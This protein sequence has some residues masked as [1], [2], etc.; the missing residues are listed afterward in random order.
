MSA[1]YVYP[2]LE[3]T[4]IHIPKT[5]GTTIRKY[6]SHVTQEEEQYHAHIPDKY[7]SFW[8]FTVVRNPFDRFISAWRYCVERGWVDNVSPLEFLNL[9]RSLNKDGRFALSSRNHMDFREDSGYMTLHHAAPMSHPDRLV[10][11]V[12]YLGRF[13]QLDD[14]IQDLKDWYEIDVEGIHEN[15]SQHEPFQ[16]YYDSMLY[17]KVLDY[18]SDD[19]DEFNYP[20]SLPLT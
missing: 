8:K 10:E 11:N 2:E 15:Q 19:F 17:H 14:V 3:I 1:I 18:Y 5:G 9:L 13:E 20:R 6:L 16:S 7:S 4:F 12:D